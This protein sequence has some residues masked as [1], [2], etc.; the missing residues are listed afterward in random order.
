MIRFENIPETP[1]V[2]V[3]A[4]PEAVELLAESF[5]QKW[6]KDFLWIGNPQ[7][8]ILGDVGVKNADGVQSG[9]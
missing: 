8:P 4:C 5:A 9:F 6:P 2:I 3:V 7:R 1:V